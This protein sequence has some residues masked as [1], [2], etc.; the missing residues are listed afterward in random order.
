MNVSSFGRRVVCDECGEQFF[1]CIAPTRDYHCCDQCSARFREEI[2][3]LN[4]F[5]SFEKWQKAGLP[6]KPDW[7]VA[8]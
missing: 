2:A 7:E 1:D 8:R 6:I 5:E 4:G 3:K